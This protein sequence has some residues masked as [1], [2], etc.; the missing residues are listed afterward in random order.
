MK[1]N[2]MY[3]RTILG[4]EV[5][6]TWYPEDDNGPMRKH[7]RLI[8]RI[9]DGESPRPTRLR[10]EYAIPSRSCGV[11]LRFKDEDD[12][13]V[14]SCFPPVA[15][16]LGAESRLLRR[17]AD[18]V[19]ALL[20]SDMG[21]TYGGREFSLRIFDWAI[22]WNLGIDDSGWTST[23][24]RWRDGNWHPIGHNQRLTEPE[25]IEEREVLVPM[26]ERSYRGKATLTRSLWGFSGLPRLFA[27][28]GHTVAID[29]LEGE[30]IPFPGKGE[31]SWDCDEDAAF[32]H[33]GPAQTIEEGIGRL[34]GSV[35]RSR[36]RH[37]GA[38]WKPA[39]KTAPA[40]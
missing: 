33:S 37:G 40:A 13:F 32:V 3:E 24:P 28:N 16:Y 8:V 2:T 19:R 21:T 35:L 15:L 20:P 6:W 10:F 14:S 36:K 1:P 39:P 11:S 7:G 38:N 31:N 34:V 26:P 12:V 29:M 25:V 4:R 27:K 9:G 22:W 18:R 5:S 17:I 23:R 30:Q